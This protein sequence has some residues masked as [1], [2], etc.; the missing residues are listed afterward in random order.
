MKRRVRTLHPGYLVGTKGHSVLRKK[1]YAVARKPSLDVEDIVVQRMPISRKTVVEYSYP[2]SVYD[3]RASAYSN[4]VV[5]DCYDL[6]HHSKGRDHHLLKKMNNALLSTQPIKSPKAIVA[7]RRVTRNSAK[8]DLLPAYNEVDLLKNPAYYVSPLPLLRYVP[9]YHRRFV[10]PPKPKRYAILSNW[11]DSF[12]DEDLYFP[13]SKLRYHH[14]TG[15]DRYAMHHHPLHYY[16]LRHHLPEWR[17]YGNR[18][19]YDYAPRRYYRRSYPTHYMALKALLVGD[20]KLAEPGHPRRTRRHYYP[21]RP[22]HR[23]LQESLASMGIPDTSG[24][25]A[26]R[27]PGYRLDADAGAEHQIP[28]GTVP[29][30]HVRDQVRGVQDKMDRHR[31]LLDRYYDRPAMDVLDTHTSGLG[32]SGARTQTDDSA[33][34]E[35]L[36]KVSPLRKKIRK[37]ICK[38]RR[39]PSYYDD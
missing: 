1:T 22:V 38:S 11:G 10:L 32:H 27:P 33:G 29:Y 37:V 23:D 13:P 7:T 3:H 26:S 4:A 39:D 6:H 25:R 17:H 15:I 31:Q 5:D 30:V 14:P 2:E 19:F 12:D 36:G 28:K 20:D 9:G 18:R 8:A 34:A 24:L 16:Y 21:E 35:M